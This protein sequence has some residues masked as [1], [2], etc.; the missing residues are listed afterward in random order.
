MSITMTNAVTS[1][2]RDYKWDVISQDGNMLTASMDHL[3]N[4]IKVLCVESKRTSGN[5]QS[6]ELPE[7]LPEH[8]VLTLFDGNKVTIVDEHHLV[9]VDDYLDHISPEQKEAR[10]LVGLSA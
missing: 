4:N 6:Y 2:L 7:P 1:K 8:N 5:G 9:L 10:S 3:K